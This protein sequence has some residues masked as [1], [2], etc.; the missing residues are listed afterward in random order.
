MDPHTHPHMWME[1]IISINFTKKFHIS[2]SFF[3]ISPCSELSLHL[4]WLNF[5]FVLQFFIEMRWYNT[6]LYHKKKNKRSRNAS[7]QL[8]ITQSSICRTARQT[9]IKAAKVPPGWQAALLPF[10]APHQQTF[11]LPCFGVQKK[12]QVDHMMGI[13]NCAALPNHQQLLTQMGCWGVKVPKKKKKKVTKNLE[14]V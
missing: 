3:H 2:E 10:R 5:T 13:N 14:N 6:P 8:C 9:R 1:F 12:P 11:Q 4:N 7:K